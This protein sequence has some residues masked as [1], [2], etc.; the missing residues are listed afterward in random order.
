MPVSGA[1]KLASLLFNQFSSKSAPAGTAR[2]LNVRTV[3]GVKGIRSSDQDVK[4][5]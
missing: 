1:G 4:G 5:L 3:E 2:M